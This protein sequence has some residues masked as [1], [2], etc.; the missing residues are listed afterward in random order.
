MLFPAPNER[1]DMP[2]ATL[3]ETFVY[4]LEEM[5]YVENQLLGVLDQMASEVTNDDLRQGL[6]RHREQTETHVAR[7]EDIFDVLG[8]PAQERESP[9]FD[10]L[11]EER[12]RFVEQ[13]TGDT[14]L[15]DLH[16]LGAAVK[17]EHLEIAS[18]ENLIML[19]RK[20]DLPNSVQSPLGENL[21]EERQTKK[22]LKAMA[23]DS[24]VRKIFARLTG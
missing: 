14:D 8:E 2:V 16:D 1:R 23:D 9:T 22:Q 18:Y 19:A 10:A 3:H 21:D 12:K 7:L 13:A 24:T 6:E 11:L 5:Y 15:R 17:N 4:H 20:L